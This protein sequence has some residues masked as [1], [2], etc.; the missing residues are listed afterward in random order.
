MW[1]CPFIYLQMGVGH[2]KF[3]AAIAAAKERAGVNLDVQ[4]S[5]DQLKELVGE[6]KGI[7]KK[8]LGVDF[9]A[10]PYEA[11]KG[12][13]MVSDLHASSL[14]VGVVIRDVPVSLRDTHPHSGYQPTT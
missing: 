14:P 1:R 3:E 9:P 5:A 4:L 6:Y 13:I 10:S 2:E 7:Y 8:A 11:L 12:A